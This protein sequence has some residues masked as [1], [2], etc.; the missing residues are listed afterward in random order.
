MGK[1]SL[2]NRLKRRVFRRLKEKKLLDNV[3][4]EL[5]LDKLLK[6]LREFYREFLDVQYK[7]RSKASGLKAGW[8]IKIKLTECAAEILGVIETI[9]LITSKNT[10][11]D[12]RS[13]VLRE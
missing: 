13:W 3:F 12:E 4:K 7:A 6:L 1:I 10:D 9:E 5:S 8:Q 2:L 11:Y